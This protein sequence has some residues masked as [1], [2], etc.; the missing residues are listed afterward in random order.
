MRT[1]GRF[2]S[3][4]EV[5]VAGRR[6]HSSRWPSRRPAPTPPSGHATSGSAVAARRHHLGDR[7]RPGPRCRRTG[8][9]PP[10]TVRT[11]RRQGCPGST[12]TA[13]V[14]TAFDEPRSCSQAETTTDHRVAHLA[15]GHRA[16]HRARPAQ[17]QQPVG[18]G[19]A[20]DRGAAVHPVDAVPQRQGLGVG[21]QVLDPAGDD[22]AARRV[23][24]GSAAPT[25]RGRSPTCSDGPLGQQVPRPLPCL[26][27][28]R[29]T[30]RRR[31]A[32]CPRGRRRSAHGRRR[33]ATT[34][35]RR[36]GVDPQPIVLVGDP[37]TRQRLPR[38]SA[39]RPGTIR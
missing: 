31:P 15:D 2:E 8:P 17:P 19:E 27:V 9:A 7:D 16:G 38:A 6:R 22:D 1:S 35:R 34:P 24:C 18:T 11:S 10:R 20:V 13:R 39:R 3:T 12:G 25:W 32:R 5:A 30:R 26:R 14:S 36:G 28:R 29:S 4:V 33:Q 23:G 37:V 21:Q